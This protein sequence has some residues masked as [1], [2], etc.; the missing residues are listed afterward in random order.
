MFLAL[1]HASMPCPAFMLLEHTII[2]SMTTDVECSAPA[3]RLP[4]SATALRIV[5]AHTTVLDGGMQVDFEELSEAALAA[6]DPWE[7]L[8][9]GQAELYEIWLSRYIK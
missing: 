5:H 2:A 4:R 3:A 7:G 9:S 8:P 1:P 6:G